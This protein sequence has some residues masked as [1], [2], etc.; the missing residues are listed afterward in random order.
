M[1]DLHC[2]ILPGLDDGPRTMDEALAMCRMAAADGITCIVAT[3]HVKPGTF[4]ADGPRIREAAAALSAALKAEGLPLILRTGAEITVTPELAGHLPGLTLNGGPYFLAEFPPS[5]VPT[6]WDCFL[7]AFLSDGRIPIIAHPER[8]AWFLNHPE[9]LFAAA[10]AGLKIQIT[11]A[12][13]LGRFGAAAQDFS[14]RLLISGRVHI[15]ASDAHSTAFRPPLLSEAAAKAAA[16]IGRPRALALVTKN[17]AAVLNG[18]PLPFTR[19]VSAKQPF[20][21][22]CLQRL[23]DYC[24]A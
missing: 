9:A 16:L 12:S 2:H 23:K 19:P 8:N 17:P 22:L 20:F 21:K 24:L 7:L 13:L 3:P 5:A 14:K 11:A 18:R 6:G 4:E 15:L 10:D 1:I